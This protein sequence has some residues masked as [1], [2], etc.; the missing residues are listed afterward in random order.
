MYI[1]HTRRFIHKFFKS[2]K[3]PYTMRI[4]SSGMMIFLLLIASGIFLRL[5]SLD[6]PLSGDDGLLTVVAQE[7][8]FFGSNVNRH[9]PLGNVFLIL[10]TTLFGLT[11]WSFKLPAFLFSVATLILLYFFTKKYY[12]QKSALWAVFFLTFSAWHIF[13]SATNM[14]SE[15]VISF[16]LVLASYFFLDYVRRSHWAYAFFIGIFIG[17]AILVKDVA[18]LLFGIFFLFMILNKFSLREIANKFFWMGLGASLCVALLVTTDYLFNDLVFTQEFIEGIF[19]ERIVHRL[20]YIEPQPIHYVYSMF[21]IVVWSSPL[22]LLFFLLWFFQKNEATWKQSMLSKSKWCDFCFIFIVIIGGFFIFYIAPVFDKSRHLL[23]TAPFFSIIAGR[24]CSQFSWSKKQLCALALL[25]LLFFSLLGVVNSERNMI[26]F[27]Q[28]EKIFENIKTLALN[29]DVGLV[30]ET[31]NPGI[32]LNFRTFLI[33]QLLG[34]IFAI[35]FYVF[36][37]L[38]TGNKYT[39]VFLLLFLSV[40]LG[41]NVFLAGELVFHITAP[42]YGIAIEEIKEY[43][44]THDLK[45]PIYIIK[46]PSIAYH[47]QEKYDRFYNVGIIENSPEKIQQFKALLQ[48]Q[49]GTVLLVDIPFV[50]KEGEL[51]Q[52]INQQCTEEF[53]VEDKSVEIGDVF[54]C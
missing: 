14:A 43:A 17:V 42:D 8:G 20:G 7:K 41:Y 21:K 49:R 48:E 12:D 4:P 18:V 6:E 44:L 30:F 13:G 51:W 28:Q 31:G 15:G 26:S 40:A 1:E 9:P 10:T 19:F 16:F 45:Q 2:Y 11:N 23:I 36:F 47:L 25:T 24:Y 37:T 3:E 27:D 38:K 39:E 52:F 46:D 29:F 50:N 53:V 33:A 32:V 35:L 22:F 34:G 5:W 54:T